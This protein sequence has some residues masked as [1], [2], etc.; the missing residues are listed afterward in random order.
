MTSEQ[1][2]QIQNKIKFDVDR[3][4][5]LKRIEDQPIKVPGSEVD[6]VKFKV[7]NRNGDTIRYTAVRQREEAGYWALY[8]STRGGEW[9][10]QFTSGGWSSVTQYVTNTDTV[11]ES[12]DY[13]G[14]RETINY[15]EN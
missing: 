10:A 11:L 6:L 7:R 9:R 12:V 8:Y 4:A 1:I 2:T 3:L 13:Y 5:A 15:T 14:P